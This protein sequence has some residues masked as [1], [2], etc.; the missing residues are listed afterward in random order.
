MLVKKVF[1]NVGNRPSNRFASGARIGN[2][3]NSRLS[4]QSPEH[5]KVSRAPLEESP[6]LEAALLL[7]SELSMEG[8]RRVVPLPDERL[9]AP[10][11]EFLEEI[12]LE[13]AERVGADP[14]PT[15]GGVS[16]EHADGRRPVDRVDGSPP[17]APEQIS[18]DL[19]ESQSPPLERIEAASLIH[20][21]VFPDRG[22]PPAGPRPQ[23]E[24]RLGIRPPGGPGVQVTRLQGT[25]PE[26]R[27]HV[28]SPGTG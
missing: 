18:S 24:A 28:G 23:Q 7:E 5:E 14:A 2:R 22:A 8:D 10:Q 6:G 19:L 26:V 15:R 4:C 11:T 21:P 12:G 17:D 25:E 3:V 27:D 13:H 9:E 16:H 1:P 20:E